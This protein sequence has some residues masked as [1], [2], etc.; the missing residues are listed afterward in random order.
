[1]TNELDVVNGNVADAAESL[2]KQAGEG[3][4][5]SGALAAGCDS[6]SPADEAVQ[7]T[8]DVSESRHVA[9]TSTA[10]ADD[11]PHRHGGALTSRGADV[12][13]RLTADVAGE[14]VAKSDEGS[15]KSSR[16]SSAKLTRTTTRSSSNPKHPK[17]TRPDSK[18]TGSMQAVR[19]VK[20]TERSS[21]GKKTVSS[22]SNI[23]GL[24]SS[25]TGRGDL[26]VS[27]SGS[28]V[29]D[30]TTRR[31][32]VPRRSVK[33]TGGTEQRRMSSSASTSTS[34][35]LSNQKTAS[36][37]SSLAAGD[38]SSNVAG[39]STPLTSSLGDCNDTS[40]S[41][42]Q[43]S[44]VSDASSLS[45]RHVNSSASSAAATQPLK[46]STV[47][48]KPLLVMSSLWNLASLHPEVSCL[49]VSWNLA[50]RRLSL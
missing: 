33:T 30:V 47:T 14:V 35:A 42:S 50:C 23:T 11:I 48:G 10:A 36:S 4:G 21:A 46:P 27:Q 40:Q 45:A 37:D 25:L 6:S 13:T 2:W 26:G 22:S 29:G 12:I 24:Q 41:I 44:S 20:K 39:V 43:L 31:P 19:S 15:Q 8:Y 38:F 17:E 16:P 34:A 32:S 1:M 28:R 5:V 9:Q 7:T 49:S 3:L 18:A